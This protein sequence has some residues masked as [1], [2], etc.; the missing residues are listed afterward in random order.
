MFPLLTSLI[1]SK[2]VFKNTPQNSDSYFK[3]DTEPRPKVF[4]NAFYKQILQKIE[5]GV[6][7]F[8]IRNLG[9]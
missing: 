7:P 2:S 5:L 6:L 3:G 1:I 4:A 9:S 8:K